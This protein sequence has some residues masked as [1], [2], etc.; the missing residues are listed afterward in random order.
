MNPNLDIGESGADAGVAEKVLE[1]LPGGRGGEVLHNDPE[2]GGP[3]RR[4]SSTRWIP[5]HVPLPL[6]L[7]VALCDLHADPTPEEL[8][9]VA[10]T[11]CV[12]Q[13]ES[14]REA[15]LA[16][17]GRWAY[18]GVTSVGKLHKGIKG[19]AGW[20]LDLDVDDLSKLKRRRWGVKIKMMFDGGHPNDPLT[21]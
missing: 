2:P 21:L 20:L 15:L 9:A 12:L 1:V 6:P 13:C 14:V 8:G 10:T 18:L 16:L 7:R 17:L 5:P 19:R 3:G 4:A 11:G